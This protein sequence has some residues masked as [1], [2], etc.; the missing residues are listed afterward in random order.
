MVDAIIFLMHVMNCWYNLV[1]FG[2]CLMGQLCDKPANFLQS[3]QPVSEQ[4]LPYRNGGLKWPERSE[5]GGTI[6]ERFGHYQASFRY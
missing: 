3:G 1:A 6:P 5:T 2:A 4:V